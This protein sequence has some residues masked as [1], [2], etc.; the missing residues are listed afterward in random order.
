MIYVE[1]RFKETD[2]VKAGHA[3]FKFDSSLD[4]AIN[5]SINMFSQSVNYIYVKD[6]ST[7]DVIKL[8]K[9][10]DGIS[11]SFLLDFLEIEKFF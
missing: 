5:T 2:I 7:Q 10:T 4:E 1:I 8:E 11:K 3:R 6:D 9:S